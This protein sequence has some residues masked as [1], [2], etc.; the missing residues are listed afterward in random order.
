MS[1]GAEPD[2]RHFLKKILNVVTALVSWAI[3]NMFFGL[4]LEWAIVHDGFNAFN[5]IFYIFFVA[6][7]SV[8]IYY[9]YRV[10]KR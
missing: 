6:S 2:I 3:I 1:S 7:L 9:F 5:I 10:W 4:Y 8:L